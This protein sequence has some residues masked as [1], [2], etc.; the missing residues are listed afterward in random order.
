MFLALPDLVATFS[1]YRCAWKTLEETAAW[2]WRRHKAKRRT[3][4][5]L[6]PS[7]FIVEMWARKYLCRSAFWISISEVAFFLFLFALVNIASI[8][9]GFIALHHRSGDLPA[10]FGMV[11]GEAGSLS[12]HREGDQLTNCIPSGLLQVDVRA[13]AKT[14][15]L[16]LLT[17]AHSLERYLKLPSTTRCNG[18]RLIAA[19]GAWV[20][21][22]CPCRTN[23]DIAS[24]L[25]K[26]VSCIWQRGS[27][28]NSSGQMC[29]HW[30]LNGSFRMVD[31]LADFDQSPDMAL[32]GR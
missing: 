20:S 24:F 8:P 19:P 6:W 29:C 4:W 14:E 23:Q 2:D 13:D 28:E 10:G 9:W 25:H 17:C 5:W 31:I 1:T 11:N 30:M 22:T 3:T 21:L 15:V 32:I 18:F 12:V 26:V 16:R 27:G 7:T